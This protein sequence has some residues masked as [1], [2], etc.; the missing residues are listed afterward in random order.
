MALDPPVSPITHEQILHGELASLLEE[1][2]YNL[3]TMVNLKLYI[4][5]FDNYL[6]LSSIACSIK[7]SKSL[8][9]YIT[10]YTNIH[11]FT[12]AGYYASSLISYITCLCAYCQETLSSMFTIS[13]L[14]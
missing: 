7:T 10:L 2:D 12:L 11:Q 6:S 5:H 8:L 13:W 4:I 9:Y 14:S 3:T 1:D